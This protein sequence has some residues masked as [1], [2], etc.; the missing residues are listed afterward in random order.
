M[1]RQWG[2][3][4]VTPEDS[5]NI[6]K[7]WAELYNT[8][9][10]IVLPP[11]VEPP[12]PKPSIFEPTSFD[13]YVGQHEAKELAIIMTD[14]ALKEKRTLPNALIS[15]EYGLGKTTLARLIIQRYGK[16]V[17]LLDGASVN[18]EIPYGLVIID[19][20]HNLAPEVADTLNTY[21]DQ[22]KTQVIGCTVNPGM[23]PSA[24]RSRFRSLHLT[25]YTVDDLTTILEKVARRKNVRVPRAILGAIALRS[26]FNARQAILYLSFI[27]DLMVVK[28]QTTITPALAYEAFSKLGV[29]ESGYL[30]RDKRYA[31]AFPDGLNPRAVGLQYLAAVTGIDEKTIEEE[32]EPYLMRTGV[33]DRTKQGRIK[34]KEI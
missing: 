3:L 4:V 9:S 13:E 27:F 10:R 17:T 30:E 29:D 1:T 33:I 18:K 26:R 24:F 15:G 12:K 20:I 16:P 7:L 34:L 31:R 6:E 32:I 28:N 22:N 5:A 14:A 25:S 11:S 19:E 8:P 23:L 2:A 21:L